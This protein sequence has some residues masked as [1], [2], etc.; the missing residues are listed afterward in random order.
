MATPT[1]EQLLAEAQ[2]RGLIPT[3]PAAPTREQLIQE[4]ARRGLVSQSQETEA[5]LTPEEFSAIQQQLGGQAGAAQA[6]TETGAGEAFL[7]STGRQF[8]RAGRTIR[9]GFAGLTGDQE[10]LAQIERERRAEAEAFAPLE[11]QRPIS[12]TAGEITGAIAATAPLGGPAAGLVTKTTTSLGPRLSTLLGFA[13]A[14]AVEEEL[15]EGNPLLGA[16]FGAGG[17]VIIES[18]PRILKEAYTRLTGQSSEGLSDI[19]EEIIVQLQQSGLSLDD[20]GKTAEDLLRKEFDVRLAP[21]AQ[22]RQARAGEFGAELT[23]AQATKDFSL[24]EAEDL[25]RKSGTPEGIEAI[26]LRSEQEQALLTG[27]EQKLLQPFESTLTVNLADKA[28][29][30]NQAEVGR[31]VRNS[32][33]EL[34]T[35]DKAVVSNLYSAAAEVPGENIPIAGDALVSTFQQAAD[36]S[37]VSDTT[38]NALFKNLANFGVAGEVIE[39][40]GNKTVVDFDGEKI[41]FFGDVKPLTLDN[42]EELRQRINAVS[43]SNASDT[44]MKMS[45]LDRLDG[46]VAE[47]VEGIPE[48]EIKREAFQRARGAASAFK[49]QFE[50]KDI[51]ER[52]LSHND[53]KG[54]VPKV[55][56]EQVLNQFTRGSQAAENTRKLKQALLTSPTPQTKQAWADFQLVT[57]EDFLKRSMVRT[58]DAAGNVTN[59]LSGNNL[60]TNLEKMGAEQAKLIFGPEMSATLKRL[61][62]VVGDATIPIKGAVNPAE[63]G[64][65][66]ANIF[67]RF[68]SLVGDIAAPGGQTRADIAGAI[69]KGKAEAAAQK[70][71]ADALA[72]VRGQ[73]LPKASVDN[74]LLE[75]ID[76]LGG[77]VGE[78]AQRL[79]VQ[80][81]GAAGAALLTPEE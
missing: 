39:K 65:R 52:L 62:Q 33:K 5:L 30:F 1:Q 80:P 15:L 4:A 55:T 78:S 77:I 67:R 56:D 24:Q 36:F 14:G 34:K 32:L 81:K 9:G 12:T 66:V 31:I 61:T 50:N 70:E 8:A 49:S 13:A 6:A 69:S 54:L 59:V 20:I 40:K 11:E 22:V 74:A 42:A 68:L 10:A 43:T 71:L 25:L 37:G 64:T 41:S 18:A 75:W 51:I 45:I 48:G 27:A 63:S 16:V 73:R 26:R 76:N 60:I 19:P 46:L 2:R 53:L 7:A 79:S 23:S 28:D 17:G 58:T 38:R 35:R 72:S 47:A 57:M 29:S 44:K 21:E 3:E